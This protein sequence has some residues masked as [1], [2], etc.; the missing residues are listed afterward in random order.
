TSITTSMRSL[1]AD[2]SN[3]ISELIKGDGNV[4]V[5]QDV[6]AVISQNA[7]RSGVGSGDGSEDGSEDG[8]GD[9][10]EDGSGDGSGDGKG[11]GSGVESENGREDE[12]IFSAILPKSKISYNT[13]I[14]VKGKD[15]VLSFPTN[16]NDVFSIIDALNMNQQSLKRH[17][18]DDRK[19]IEIH[20][21]ARMNNDVNCF[22]IQ[23]GIRVGEGKNDNFYICMNYNTDGSIV[24]SDDEARGFYYTSYDSYVKSRFKG[25]VDK[26]FKPTNNF[27]LY[28]DIMTE[29]AV[30]AN[31]RSD[32][33]KKASLKPTPPGS[34]SSQYS[35]AKN[36][37]YPNADKNVD[38]FAQLYDLDRHGVEGLGEV[39][40]KRYTSDVPD[41]LRDEGIKIESIQEQINKLTD[42]DVKN[43][44]QTEFILAQ[45]VNDFI[46]QAHDFTIAE[47]EKY[48]NFFVSKG[49]VFQEALR[50]RLS[51]LCSSNYKINVPN[52]HFLQKQNVS[53]LVS[54]LRDL[55]IIFPDIPDEK[56]QSRDQV[57]AEF[58]ADIMQ[59]PPPRRSHYPESGKQITKGTFE[60][61]YRSLSDSDKV[62]FIKRVMDIM[63]P[64]YDADVS[65]KTAAIG[66]AKTSAI[67]KVTAE[68]DT[69]SMAIEG[70]LASRD[71]SYPNIPRR[72]DMDGCTIGT[73]AKGD[74]VNETIENVHGI[75]DVHI[76][77]KN[78]TGFTIKIGF[79]SNPDDSLL[80][81]SVPSQKTIIY[82]DV[83]KYLHINFNLPIQLRGDSSTNYEDFYKSIVFKRGLDDEMKIL[84]VKMLKTICD[85]FW[86]TSM[87]MSSG[88]ESLGIAP[89][90]TAVCTTDS[91][92][93]ADLL[94][95]YLT[96]KFTWLPWTFRSGDE[97][98][99]GKCKKGDE[100]AGAGRG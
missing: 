37:R 47:V 17:N 32:R 13:T 33:E 75:F 54:K 76:V 58:I 79:S 41:S 16:L 3:F 88:H 31:I 98:R 4:D 9:G 85:K 80:E 27:L 25:V 28:L 24:I 52:S 44:I 2:I 84:L 72:V 8:N 92:V 71:I 63:G 96:G 83:A 70:A 38:Y 95:A 39:A 48:V 73:P 10:S 82:D 55:G 69:D 6:S 56:F 67:G 34:P 40:K 93:W 77:G 91:Y 14:K 5:S 99:D 100:N 11:K 36:P 12:N 26:R 19:Q 30:Q 53:L 43:Q 46:D 87:S 57:F 15:I 1:F 86:R 42:P 45:A 50:K 89:G 61:Y 60:T 78:E 7:D 81:M 18:E 21:Y 51:G 74:D 64:V 59:S 22:I 20:Q 94:L 97:S 23:L 90:V 29:A 49:P 68:A 35:L 62:S 65:S 66:K